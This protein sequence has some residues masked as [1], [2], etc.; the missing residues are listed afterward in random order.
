MGAF[1][2][3]AICS[4]VGVGVAVREARNSI[5]AISCSAFSGVMSS[6]GFDSLPFSGKFVP[7][8]VVNNNIVVLVLVI[9]VVVFTIE[10][11]GRGGTGG[12]GT[13]LRRLTIGCGLNR[14]NASCSVSGFSSSPRGSSGHSGGGRECTRRIRRR[15]TL[16]NEECTPRPVVRGV[17]RP[18]RVADRCSGFNCSASSTG[19]GR[20]SRVVGSTGTC[21]DRLRHRTCGGGC[22]CRRGDARSRGGGRPATTSASR[23]RPRGVSRGRGSGTRAPRGCRS[24]DSSSNPALIVPRPRRSLFRADRPSSVSHRSSTSIRRARR[25][26]RRGRPLRGGISRCTG[27]VFNDSSPR[28]R[29]KRRISSRRLMETGTGGGGFSD[30]CSFFSR[31]PGGSVKIVGDSSLESTRSFSIVNRIREGTRAMG[32]GTLRGRGGGRARNRPGSG[33][34]ARRI[35]TGMNGGVNGTLENFTNKIGGFNVRYKCFYGGISVVVGR[36]H[37]V[38]GHGGTRRREE[39]ERERGT[40]HTEVHTT[41]N[42]DSKLIRIRDE[43]SHHPRRGHHPTGEGGEE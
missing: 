21:G 40:R 43:A 3:G 13:V 33:Q 17:R 8:V 37:T 30:N 28:R 6:M 12:G 38:T 25:I 31:T 7:C 4:N 5:A 23:A 26:S 2:T 9:L 20:V 34:S 35:L 16:P 10:V 36:G 27:V 29:A 14:G 15:S 42:R 41:E 18:R 39:R 24:V 32:R 1:I 19:R 11:E 22:N